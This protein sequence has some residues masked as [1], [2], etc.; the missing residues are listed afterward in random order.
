MINNTGGTINSGTVTNTG[1]VNNTG[2]TINS[3]TVTNTGVSTTTASINGGTAPNTGDVLHDQHGVRFITMAVWST[4][5][6]LPTR[7]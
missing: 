1:V 6:P 2:G 5:A 3:G 7:G 4:P